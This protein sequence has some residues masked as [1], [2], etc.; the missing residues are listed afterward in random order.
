MLGQLEAGL[1]QLVAEAARIA[2][3]RRL[4]TT[5]VGMIDGV[6][7]PGS[8]KR[9]KTLAKILVGVVSCVLALV[10]W[11]I[12]SAREEKHLKPPPSVQ[13]IQDFL[14][15]MPPPTRVQKFSFG[16]ASYYE[17]WGQS[18]GSIRLPSG[19]PSYIFDAKG[20]LVDWTYDRGDA[21]DYL[22]KW[23]R[24]KDAKSISVQEMLQDV[25]AERGTP[26][27][28]FISWQA[29]SDGQRVVGPKAADS[30]AGAM[31]RNLWVEYPE[32][33]YYAMS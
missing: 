27:A 7:W 30:H 15:Q 18:G 29:F 28:W 17:V 13:S 11:L 20:R 25:A 26:I 14:Q 16:G 31:P 33:M 2:A 19:P 8:M 4:A 32:A 3:A 23:G 10:V 21:G 1:A 24:F 12:L 22:R 5:P 9:T 6:M